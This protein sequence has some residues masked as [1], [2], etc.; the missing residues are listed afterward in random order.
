[1]NQLSHFWVY[2]QVWCFPSHASFSH[3]ETSRQL[4]IA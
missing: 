4:T 2:L 3:S 1:M